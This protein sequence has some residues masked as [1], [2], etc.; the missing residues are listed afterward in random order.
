MKKICL[1]A[2][3]GVLPVH[4]AVH[5]LPLARE[6]QQGELLCWAAVSAMASRAFESNGFRPATQK[7]VVWYEAA[8][9]TDAVPLVAPPYPAAI[10]PAVT[11]C[12]NNPGTGICNANKSPWLP[13]LTTTTVATLQLPGQK[14]MLSEGHFL[15]DIKTRKTP[16]IIRWYYQGNAARGPDGSLL[17]RR[18][19]GHVLL[20]TGIDTGTKELRVWDPW[21]HRKPGQSAAGERL[22]PGHKREKWISFGRY[23]NPVKDNG[24][25]VSAM[26]GFDEFSLRK[27]TEPF[28]PGNYPALITQAVPA[29]QALDCDDRTRSFDFRGGPPDVQKAAGEFMRKLVIRDEEGRPRKARLDPPGEPIPI[30]AFGSE[31]L[32]RARS[33]PEALLE[34]RTT[35]VIV[36]VTENGELVDSFLMLREGERWKE[37]GYSNNEIARL[38]LEVRNRAENR[39]RTT[40][41]FYLV[42]IPEEGSFFATHGFG[43]DAEMIPLA[44]DAQGR[45]VPARQWLEPVIR[46][47]ERN[48]RPEVT[49]Q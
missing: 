9:V 48:K 16:V 14:K 38:L 36:P 5:T 44:D 17:P 18:E 8:G 13:G 1:L 31:D 22:P 15:F 7:E 19:G 4:A 29:R 21:P 41:G 2:L 12:T 27:S 24:W 43:R 49:A 47:A 3:L 10:G 28:T 32:L 34:S 46:Q 30:V 39:E 40:R 37:G 20:V 6:V 45:F 35:A 23:K 25:L 33:N 42:S 26:H 11:M